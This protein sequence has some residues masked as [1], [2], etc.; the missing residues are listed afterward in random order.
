MALIHILLLQAA[1]RVAADPR[2]RTKAAEIYQNEVKPRARAALREAK[3]RL[4]A[5]KLDLQE[6]ARETDP[7]RDPKGF[8]MRLK[9]RFVDR[10]D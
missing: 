10:D 4:A 9:R 1:R 7:R 6:I 2:V 5:V 8:A 3:P